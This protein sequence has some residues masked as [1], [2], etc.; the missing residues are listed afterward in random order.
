MAEGAGNSPQ[1]S[2][3]FS[4]QNSQ[5]RPATNTLPSIGG[6]EALAATYTKYLERSPG[7]MKT[8]S[9]T[10]S[11]LGLYSDYKAGEAGAGRLIGR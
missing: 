3:P 11:K 8:N 6:Q 4:Q 2:A 7:V 5:V 1:A 10:R 9:M